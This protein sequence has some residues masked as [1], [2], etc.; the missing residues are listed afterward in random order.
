M[1]CAQS[2]TGAAAVPPATAAARADAEGVVNV[3]RVVVAV[4]VIITEIDVASTASIA[5]KSLCGKAIG[6][7]SAQVQVL[8]TVAAVI[9]PA[10][11]VYAASA[12]PTLLLL[13]LQR[14]RRINKRSSTPVSTTNTATSAVM[15]AAAVAV[16]I[17]RPSAPAAF[18]FVFA[19]AVYAAAARSRPK[20][21]RVHRAFAALHSTFAPEH[22]AATVVVVVAAVETIV[23]VATVAA[24]ELKPPWRQAGSSIADSP[25]ASEG[26][27]T[28]GET[29]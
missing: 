25:M 6:V 24:V 16:V 12:P 20:V 21:R 7:R 8:V 13:L 14:M 23:A 19:L 26:R 22:A 9:A 15:A 10:T 2:V 28:I 11:A 17:P 4:A 1:P 29:I 3:K 18:A 5:P 27:A